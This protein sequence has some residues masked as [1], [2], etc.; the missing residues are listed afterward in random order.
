MS[1]AATAPRWKDE[2]G[3]EVQPGL[4]CDIEINI[5]T[6]A[7]PEDINATT[8][9]ALREIAAQIEADTLDTGFHPIKD[10]N[11]EEIGQV[12]LDHHGRIE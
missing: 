9:W 11:G 1:K 6:G 2:F 7:T 4:K 8:A 3:C 12:Y 5:E 10:P